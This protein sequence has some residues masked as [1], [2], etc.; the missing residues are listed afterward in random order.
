MKR[1]KLVTG[2]IIVFVLGILMGSL[3]TGLLYKYRV[4]RPVKP[5]PLE[6]RALILKR[7][8]KAL[9]LSPEQSVG[10]ENIIDDM[11]SKRRE[12]FNKIR[13]EM[14]KIREQGVSKMKAILEPHQQE[15]LDK[16]HQTFRKRYKERKE[17]R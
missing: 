12:F 1:W 7:Y 16:L 4:I 2:V 9:A 5:E 15:K 13:P 8:S 14:R 3:G 6:K 17:F 11:D 10:F